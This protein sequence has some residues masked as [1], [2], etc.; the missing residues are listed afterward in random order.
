MR[1]NQIV[2]FIFLILG[3]ILILNTFS[4]IS[5]YIIIEEIPVSSSG[6]FGLVFL[7]VG[8]ILV[9]MEGGLEKITY[10]QEIKASG[11]IIT[12]PR[13]LIKI[14]KKSGYT[15]IKRKGGEGSRVLKPD[16][17]NL[18]DIPRHNIST[19]VYRSIITALATG[20]SSYRKRSRYDKSQDYAS[21]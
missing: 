20:E 7:L 9:L 21:E 15:V 8:I 4:G 1:K 13:K 12:S 17:S 19:N 2:G 11:A 16:G 18:T 6:F 14:A 5:G 10:A 3:G